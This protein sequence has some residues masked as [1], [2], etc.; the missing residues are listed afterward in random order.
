MHLN[1]SHRLLALSL[2]AVV[3]HDAHAAWNGYQGDMGHTGYVDTAIRIPS[4]TPKWWVLADHSN[5]LAIGNGLL[6]IAPMAL[7]AASTGIRTHNLQTGELVWELTYPDYLGSYSA[8]ALDDHGRIYF[9]QGKIHDGTPAQ[10]QARDARTGELEW[11]TEVDLQWQS[12]LSPVIVDGM[13]AIPAGQSAAVHAFDQVD[14]TLLNQTWGLGNSMWT[15]TPWGDDHWVAYT[16]RV[17]LINRHTGEVL[18]T[19]YSVDFWPADFDIRQTVVVVNDVAYVN[20]ESGKLFGFALPSLEVVVQ[21]PIGAEQQI[22]TNGR[23]LFLIADD[24]FTVTDLEGEI[25]WDVP[26]PPDA[27]L[28]GPI[29]VTN[30][31]ALVGAYYDWGHYTWVIDLRTRQIRHV[32]DGRGEMALAENTMIIKN[33]WA[34]SVGAYA[35]QQAMFFGDFED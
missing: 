12:M 9:L 18:G 24:K 20:D 31:H 14:G 33:T 32:I 7:A 8:P 26:S 17:H 4:T 19:S 30:S 22:S 25:L 29:L 11:S 10:V 34:T 1:A 16:G 28:W 2:A 13:V 5:G 3:C 23:E 35:A 15:V 6:H 21:K 27:S